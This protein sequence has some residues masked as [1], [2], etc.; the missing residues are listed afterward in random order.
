MGRVKDKNFKNRFLHFLPDT[1]YVVTLKP[2]ASPVNAYIGWINCPGCLLPTSIL[3]REI[4]SNGM[5]AIASKIY[6]DYP[7]DTDTVYCLVHSCG[8]HKIVVLTR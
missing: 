4:Y 2:F 6:E 8:F 7:N 1:P 3:H 5:L